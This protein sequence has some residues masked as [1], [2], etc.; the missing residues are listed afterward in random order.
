[1]LN[2]LH[3]GENVVEDSFVKLWKKRQTI[4]S[5]SSIKPYLYRTVRNG[6][7]D[8]LR[9]Q[10]HQLAYT[11]HIKK[12]PE[13]TSPDVTQNIIL[14]E[15]M[16][17]VFLALENLPAKYRQL[18]NMIYVEGKAVKDVAL[19]LDLPLSTVK[20]QKARALELLRKQLPHLGCLLIFYYLK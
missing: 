4:D 1:M 14:S 20:S 3:S 2:N 10:K 16:H 9:K 6:C 11:N 7:I 18:L 8:L 5:P 17:Q 13:Q 15:S 19:E 12:I